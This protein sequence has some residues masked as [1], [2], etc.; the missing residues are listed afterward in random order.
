[1][2]EISRGAEHVTFINTFRCDPAH[3]DDVV[4]INID[5][6]DK[7]ASRSPGFIAAAVHRST[8]GT[9]VFNYLQWRSAEN[10]AAMKRSPE[11]GAIAH[12]FAG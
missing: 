8:D 7:V 6:V 12:R 10:L 4:R 11:F 3:Q 2:I 5:I 1:M 9:R